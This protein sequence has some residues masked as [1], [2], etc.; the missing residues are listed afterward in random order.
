MSGCN[1]GCGGGSTTGITQ[2]Y[3]VEAPVT[4]KSKPMTALEIIQ[5]IKVTRQPNVDTGKKNT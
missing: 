2:Q 5:A 1:G 4:N 3:S